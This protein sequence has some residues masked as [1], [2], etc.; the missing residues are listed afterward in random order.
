LAYFF[1]SLNYF[2]SPTPTLVRYLQVPE[3]QL[4][5]P[6]AGQYSLYL[7]ARPFTFVLGDERTP[8]FF[9]M[10]LEIFEP[11]TAAGYAGN[12]WATSARDLI[13]D[14]GRYG[15][16]AAIL[17]LSLLSG[18]AFAASEATRRHDRRVLACFVLIGWFWFPF[19]LLTTA[20][21]YLVPLVVIAAFVVARPLWSE[22][23][24]GKGYGRGRAHFPSS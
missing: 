7:L 13:V 1:V 21:M 16:I 23:E 19:H 24:A 4:A 2:S 8:S 3:E 22:T 12:V 15:A 11:L 10:R 17:V 18:I 9:D 6:Y 20:T 5:G 14:F